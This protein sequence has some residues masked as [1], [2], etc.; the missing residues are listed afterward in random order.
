[1]QLDDRAADPANVFCEEPIEVGVEGCRHGHRYQVACSRAKSFSENQENCTEP[2]SVLMPFC[3]HKITVPCHRES[4]ISENPFNCSARCHRKIE[5]CGHLCKRECGHCLDQTLEKNPQFILSPSTVHLMD[6]AKCQS[7]C[8][9]TLFC[10]H[11]CKDLCHPG[12]QQIFFCCL[13][14]MLADHEDCSPCQEKCSIACEHQ[15]EG[16]H[17]KCSDQREPCAESCSWKCEHQGEC[18]LPCGVPCK[19]LPCDRRCSKRL[20]CGC[21]CPSL[22]GEECPSREFCHVHAGPVIKNM[23]RSLPYPVHHTFSAHC[24]R[25]I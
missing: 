23:V 24:R 3:G 4:T 16:N 21:Q 10:G 14:K 11:L 18:T 12:E 15:K 25:S 9:K 8:G 7:L 19:R 20:P 17:K 2:V 6:H 1:M 5:G 13:W 22:C